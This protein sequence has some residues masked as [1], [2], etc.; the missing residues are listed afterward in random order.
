MAKGPQCRKEVDDVPESSKCQVHRSVAICHRLRSGF[1]RFPSGRKHPHQGTILAPVE[2]NRARTDDGFPDATLGSIGI[3]GEARRHVLL[4][5]KVM[6]QVRRSRE[7]P[8]EFRLASVPRLCRVT[9]LREHSCLRRVVDRDSGGV[10]IVVEV[11]HDRFSAGLVGLRY[12]VEPVLRKRDAIRLEPKKR[13]PKPFRSPSKQQVRSNRPRSVR[14][15][16]NL[17]CDGVADHEE[18]PVDPI[19]FPCRRNRGRNQD[20]G[21][22]WN[23]IGV[24]VSNP[25]AKPGRGAGIVAGERNNDLHFSASSGIQQPGSSS[26][27]SWSVILGRM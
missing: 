3:L 24:Q 8:K 4:P 11:R 25:P 5:P 14:I 17:H 1:G 19:D 20:R 12:L 10:A 7:L 21:R 26:E 22:N 15:L 2:N 9:D 27:S 16:T 13:L 18:F 23:P 6:D